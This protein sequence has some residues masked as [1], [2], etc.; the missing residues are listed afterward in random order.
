MPAAVI[1]GCPEIW[2][3]WMKSFSIAMALIVFPGLALIPLN[4]LGLSQAQILGLNIP[5]VVPLIPIQFGGY[6]FMLSL[7]GKAFRIKRW[8]KTVPNACLCCLYPLE[9]PNAICSECGRRQ[10]PDDLSPYWRKHTP[11]CPS[12][13]PQ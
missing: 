6:L 7:T 12:D 1:K 10:N 13:A 3:R 8:L 11:R 2:R 4:I 9:H 5:L